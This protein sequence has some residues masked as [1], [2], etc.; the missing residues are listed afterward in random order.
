MFKPTPFARVIKAYKD[1]QKAKAAH[2][3]SYPDTSAA[4]RAT[5]LKNIKKNVTDVVVINKAHQDYFD[6][7]QEKRKTSVAEK[8]FDL[9]ILF[10]IIFHF[11]TPVVGAQFFST[12]KYIF[13]STLQKIHTEPTHKPF[14][15]LIKI[16][17]GAVG[18]YVGYQA[19]FGLF[20][21]GASYIAPLGILY[22]LYTLFS[23]RHTKEWGKLLEPVFSI[24]LFGLILG[25]PSVAPIIASGTSAIAMS[26][27]GT[28]IAEKLMHLWNKAWYGHYNSTHNL[29]SRILVNDLLKT[30]EFKDS[31]KYKNQPERLGMALSNLVDSGFELSFTETSETPTP[32]ATVKPVLATVKGEQFI[33][34]NAVPM[35]MLSAALAA[36]LKA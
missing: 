14:K 5:D 30:P 21:L 22:G 33:R 28:K 18:G 17:L 29:P 15:S 8:I 6:K 35:N 19:G 26:F 12:A 3:V 9:V 10:P 1:S 13:F 11:M 32:A 2:T 31:P 34:L 4:S 24:S 20:I 16:T 25:V 36:T 27:L 23:E 7:L